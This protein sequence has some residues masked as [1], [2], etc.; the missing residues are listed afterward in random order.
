MKYILA[1]DLGTSGNKATLYDLNGSLKAFSVDEYPTFYPMP[2]AVEQNPADWWNSVCKSTR[3]LMQENNIAPADIACITFSG[4]MMGC[5][6]VGTNGEILRN[7]IIWADSRSAKQE[8]FMHSQMD[9]YKFY[10]ITGHRPTAFYSLAKLLWVK[11]NEPETYKK[12]HKMLNA[13][14]YIVYKLTGELV[15]DYSDAASTNIFDIKNK[16][17]SNEIINAMGISENILPTLCSSMDI[18]GNGLTKEAAEATGLLPGTKVVIGGGDGACAATGAGAVEEGLAY[19]VIGS[20]SWISNASKNLV[21]DAEMKT[22]NWVALDPN[23]YTPCGTMQAAG[24]SLRWLKETLCDFEGKEAKETARNVYDIINEKIAT[25]PPGANN[26]LFLPYLLGERSPRWNANAKGAFLG[27]TMTSNKNDMMR[28]VLEGVGYNLKVI[29]DTITS[30]NPVDKIT[31]IG[32]GAKSDIWLQILA[33]IWQKPIEVPAYLEE[34][35][36]MGAAICAG[37][38]I[39]AF[40]SFNVIHKFNKTV[41]TVTPNKDNAITY[42]RLYTM[43]NQV[44]AALEGNFNNWG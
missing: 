35:T 33:D 2:N 16:V 12:A 23:Y 31:A 22:F 9:Q 43:F 39:G 4:Q 17:W 37:C 20:S 34:A 27:L 24:Y 6:L 32:G 36:S 41:K 40:P 10:Q 13:K 18:I 11:D 28:S 26:I 42:E 44:Y 15:T 30:E 1:H 38:A 14:D 5:V 7:A 29:L 25:S 21:L 19:I 3:N 8:A